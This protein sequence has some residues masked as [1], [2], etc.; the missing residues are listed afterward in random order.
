MAGHEQLLDRVRDLLA[1]STR[2]LSGV[3]GSPSLLD[4][5]GAAQCCFSL[6][7]VVCDI[8]E[9]TAFFMAT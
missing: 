5:P 1:A 2:F 8:S 4:G 3:E 9:E 6:V 7:V